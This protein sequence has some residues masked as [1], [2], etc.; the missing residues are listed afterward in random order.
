MNKNFIKRLRLNPLILLGSLAVISMMVSCGDD[1]GD[2]P[3]AA[4]PAV[5]SISPESGEAGDNVTITGTDLGNATLVSFGTV[6]ATIVSNTA[7]EIVATVPESAT[8]GKVSVT[9]AGGVGI[10]PGDFTVV[11][12]GAVTITEVSPVSAEIGGTVMITGTDMATVSSVKIGTT[13]ATIVGT[14]DTSVEI[15]VGTGTPLGLST[16]TVVNDGGTN[17]TST[18]SLK[19]YVI[20]LVDQNM[21]GDFEDSADPDKKTFTGSADAEES[22]IHGKSNDPV[23]L[24]NA[25]ALPPAIDGVFFQMEGFSSTDFSGSYAAGLN[26]S[27]QAAGTF[28]DFFGDATAEEIYF[29]IL[30][31]FGTLPDGYAESENEEDY[32]A[33]FRFRFDG[34]DYEY[35]VTIKELTDMGFMPDENGWYDLSVP[36]T[37]FTDD[38]ALGTFAFGDLLRFGLASRRNYGSGTTL[39]LSADNGGVFWSMSFDNV[40]ISVG[41]PHSSL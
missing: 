13:D 17:T 14:T 9:T 38:A 16:I 10:S 21:I 18:E 3:G 26:L 36:A 25:T 20:K 1:D 24:E 7:T 29:N 23:V 4:I 19:F 39:P 2:D 32:V 5:I 22:T 27:T 15:M 34:D 30:I 31:N 8:T 28:T 12:I 41:G 33:G 37:L 6:P 11:I 40:S 35:R